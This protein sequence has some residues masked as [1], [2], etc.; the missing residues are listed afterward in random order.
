MKRCGQLYQGLTKWTSIFRSCI[1][2]GFLTISA[3][4]FKTV[5]IKYI[6]KGVVFKNKNLKS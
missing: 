1:R 5:F 6:L 2:L 3:S 4:A